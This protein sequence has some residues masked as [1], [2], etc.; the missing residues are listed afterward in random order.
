[1][2]TQQLKGPHEAIICFTAVSIKTL[3]GGSSTKQLI[4]IKHS[5]N[6][7][8]LCASFHSLNKE[9]VLHKITS[10]L[11]NKKMVKSHGISQVNKDDHYLLEIVAVSVHV[12]TQAKE[13]KNSYKPAIVS[14]LL[15]NEYSK[16]H[17]Y[18][19]Q[20]NLQTCVNFLMHG[21]R[22]NCREQTS[23]YT[24]TNNL[25]SAC[26]FS[27]FFGSIMVYTNTHVASKWR[28]LC[29]TQ[30]PNLQGNKKLII[31]VYCTTDVLYINVPSISMQG[32]DNNILGLF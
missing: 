1:M 6:R 29:C 22:F 16:N 18:V 4:R 12:H 5:R 30:Q 25:G 26:T 3:S 9:E 10:Q 19:L 27:Y 23:V 28:R 32:Q 2:W 15:I 17:K 14:L 8:S 24:N 13:K 7:W 31:T 20:L 21:V 11:R